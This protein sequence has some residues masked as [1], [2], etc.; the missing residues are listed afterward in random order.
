MDAIPYL[1]GGSAVAALALAAYFFN[2]V[3]AADPGNDRMQYLMKEIQDGSRAFLKK[4][5][6]WV[7]GFVV[8]M[9]VLIA[10]LLNPLSAV[11]YVIGAI[12]SA[13]AGWAGMTVATMANARTTNA[14]IEGPQK[15]LPLAFKGGAVMG[16]SVAGLSLL[17]L[18]F[19][20]LLF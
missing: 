6:T 5:Y 16:F 10:V 4:E 14:A 15:A 2:V 7:A 12:L 3:K 13:G 19:L 1:A 8:I 17:G 11:S 20:Y 18:S 9:I